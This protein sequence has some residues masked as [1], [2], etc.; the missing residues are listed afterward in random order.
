MQVYKLFFKI[1]SKHIKSSLIYLGIFLVLIFMMTFSGKKEMNSRFEA[2]SVDITIIDKDNSTLSKALTDYLGSIHNLTPLKD[3]SDEYLQDS[4]FYQ[5]ISY[6]LKIPKGFENELANGNAKAILTHS[7]RQDSACGYFVNMQVNNYLSSVSLYLS[8]G[9]SLDQAIS[10]TSDAITNTPDIE[11][12]QF[13]GKSEGGD[14]TLFYYYQYMSY[15]LI[16]IMIM[17]LSPILTEFHKKDLA[18]RINCSSTRSGWKNFQIGLG[19]MTYSLLTWLFFILLAIIVFHPANVFTQNS[20]MNIAS[21]FVYTLICTTIALLIGNFT[22]QGSGLHLL[23]NFIA[24]GMSFLCGVFVP[25][26]YLGETV[27]AVGKFLPA[28]WYMKIV[29]MT[30]GFSGEELSIAN[31]WNYLGIEAIF[32]IAIF[33]VYLVFSQQRKRRS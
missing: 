11:L 13:K 14:T 12:L 6:V 15:T 18:D 5:R 32:L 28:F 23:C 8:A 2:K 4:L 29:N 33:A 7:M 20:L 19:C 17:G 1:A 30:S 31:F 16:M 24:L 3:Y 22:L 10:M 27:L 26:W 25:Q 21:S 9:Y